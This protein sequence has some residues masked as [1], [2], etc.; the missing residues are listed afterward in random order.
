[1][2]TAWRTF[3]VHTH[4]CNGVDLRQLDVK[5]SLSRVYMRINRDQM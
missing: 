5:D 3:R 4:N 2:V 1:M